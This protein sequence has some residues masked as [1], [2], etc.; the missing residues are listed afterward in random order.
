MEKYKVGD[1]VYVDGFIGASMAQQN[2]HFSEVSEVDI[3]YDELTGKPFQIVK[4]GNDWYYEDGNCYSNKASFYYIEKV[5]EKK[6]ILDRKKDKY[7]EYMEK[8]KGKRIKGYDPITFDPYF[9]E[10]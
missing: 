5:D 1:R 8:N 3:R 10:D 2:A 4:V 7:D 6:S 9:Y